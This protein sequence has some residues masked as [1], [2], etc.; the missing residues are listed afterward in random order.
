MSASNR[1]GA[2]FMTLAMAFFAVEDAFFK[3]ATQDLSVGLAL[4]LF[5][6]FGFAGFAILCLRAGEPIWHPSNLERTMLIRSAFELTGRLFYALALA[7][8]PA[9]QHFG[10]PASRAALRHAGCRHCLR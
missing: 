5:G 9:G 2:G 4:L 6:A 1:A 3:A 7:F 8:A 10:N